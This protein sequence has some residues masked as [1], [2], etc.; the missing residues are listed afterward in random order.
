MPWRWC[1]P[2]SS[3]ARP[4]SARER[5]T[6]HTRVR[7]R[8]VVRSRP[9]RRNPYAQSVSFGPGPLTPAVQ[10]LIVANVVMFV[11]TTVAPRLSIV[12]GLVPAAVF[13]QFALWQP[14]T[15]AFLHLDLMHLVFN[16]LALWM[17]GVELERLWG[18]RAFA[19]YY[20]LCGVGAAATTLLVSLLP[21]E[22]TSSIYYTNTIGAS[23]AV[24]GLLFAWAKY[25]P[26]RQVLMFFV[27]PVPARIFVTIMGAMSL[28]FAVSSSGSGVAHV[29]HL[30][31]FVAGWLYLRGQG[32][33]G[34]G[35]GLAAEIK[36]RYLKWKMARMRRNFDVVAGG[37]SRWDGKH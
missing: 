13:G 10:A 20:A 32:S 15:Y 7:P 34:G 1:A 24:Y 4:A 11:L 27:F 17:F 14:V 25:F 36:Y 21:F 16:M 37:R 5:S 31:G 9:V 23:G 8:R 28:Y 12:L 35:G 30:G 6:A 18:T 22:P 3:A 29:T 26:S 33:R 2:G 19:I